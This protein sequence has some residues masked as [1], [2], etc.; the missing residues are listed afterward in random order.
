VKIENT[1]DGKFQ[2]FRG[3]IERVVSHGRGMV[4]TG[5]PALGGFSDIP[6]G[7]GRDSRFS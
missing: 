5:C 7:S 2:R 4:W 3:G 6:G 1:V